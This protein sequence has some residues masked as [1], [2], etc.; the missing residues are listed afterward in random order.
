MKCPINPKHGELS[1]LVRHT[2]RIETNLYDRDTQAYCKT[3]KEE[4]SDKIQD[5]LIDLMYELS[6]KGDYED[7][8]STI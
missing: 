5:L 6:K 7:R 3:C 4:K 2:V 1:V 8:E